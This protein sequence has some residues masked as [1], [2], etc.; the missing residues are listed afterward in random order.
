M[1]QRCFKFNTVEEI[2]AALD[3]EK[4]E[5]AAETKATMLEL[6]PTSLKV[7]L[8]QLRIGAKRSIADCFK[9][10]YKLAEKI[11]VSMMV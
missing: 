5:W 4:S 11:V 2:V 7:T 10:E 9:M 8:Q 3:K 6:S 1:S